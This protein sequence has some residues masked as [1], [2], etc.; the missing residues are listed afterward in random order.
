L[1]QRDIGENRFKLNASPLSKLQSSNVAIDELVIF[2]SSYPMQRLCI[3]YLLSQENH[4]T[5]KNRAGIVKLKSTIVKD[6][7]PKT[8]I[9][10]G[11]AVTR[12]A[13]KQP[14]G[15]CVRGS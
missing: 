9:Q 11:S 8:H 1:H 5:D 6:F 10:A 14:A 13:W 15:W 2:E 7:L 12:E 3:A 4:V